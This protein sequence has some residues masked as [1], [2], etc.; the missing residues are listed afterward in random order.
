MDNHFD[1]S[2]SSFRDSTSASQANEDFEY[3]PSPDNL[4]V[5][6]YF[7]YVDHGSVPGL[8]LSDWLESERIIRTSSLDRR[9]A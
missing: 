3:E 5:A 1:A 4:I 7:R 8:E 2:F 6:A 9:E